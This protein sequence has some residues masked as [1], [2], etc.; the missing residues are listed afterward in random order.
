MLKRIL[1]GLLFI[2]VALPVSGSAYQQVSLMQDNQT[3]PPPG[4]LI[5]IGGYS[6]HIHCIGEGEPTLIIDTGAADWS[7]SWMAIQPDLAQLTRTCIYDRAGLGWSEASPEPRTSQQ[8]V[9]ELHTLLNNANIEPP[10]ILLG[11]SLGGYNVRI[12]QEQYPDEVAG[13]ILADSAHPGQWDVLPPEVENLVSQQVGL[14]NNMSMLTNFGVVR[15][16]LPE[17]AYLSEDWQ[18]AYSSHMARS[19]H[20][21]ASAGELAGGIGL[22]AEQAAETGDSGDLPLVVVTAG[23]SFDAFRAMTDD[24]PFDEAEATWQELQRDLA[25]LSS[26]SVHLVSPDAHHTIQLTDPDIVIEAVETMLGMLM[27]E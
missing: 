10:Y 7:V 15:L 27:D 24:I 18:D 9:N 3:Y 1:I 23:R 21:L 22:S 6:L 14:L 20:L 19:R 25:T 8:L 12:Y 13:I 11:H 16:I 26:N 4:E 17:H 2:L 5:D